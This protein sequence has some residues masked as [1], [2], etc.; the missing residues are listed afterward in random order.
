MLVGTFHIAYNS[1]QFMLY[2][3]GQKNDLKRQI[4]KYLAPYERLC[5]MGLNANK[6][7]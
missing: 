6:D 7:I 1:E 5:T 3:L 4:Q 2:F